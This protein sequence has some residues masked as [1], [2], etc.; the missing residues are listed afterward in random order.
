MKIGFNAPTAGPLSALDPL[1]RLCTGAEELGFDYATFSDHVVIPTDISSPYPYSATGEF[2]NQGNGERISHGQ[3]GGGTGRRG[4]AK[5]AG[6]LDD[7]HID[8]DITGPGQR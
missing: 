7:T 5:G 6:L 8:H 3:S 4:E 2:S 1:T